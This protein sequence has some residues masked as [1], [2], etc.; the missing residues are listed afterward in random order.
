MAGWN[1]TDLQCIRVLLIGPNAWIMKIDEV[2]TVQVVDKDFFPSRDHVEDTIR[3]LDKHQIT[4]FAYPSKEENRNLVKSIR[5][6]G[7]KPVYDSLCTP[8]RLPL[9]CEGSEYLREYEHTPGEWLQILYDIDHFPQ[10]RRLECHHFLLLK[11]KEREKILTF[12]GSRSKM[13]EF[14]NSTGLTRNTA[15]AW[16]QIREFDWEDSKRIHK[17][18]S[19]DYVERRPIFELSLPL[20]PSFQEWYSQYSERSR[21]EGDYGLCLSMYFEYNYPCVGGFCIIE[22]IDNNY[23]FDL[24]YSEDFKKKYNGLIQDLQINLQQKISVDFIELRRTS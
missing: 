12:H 5:D 17:L 22:E 13:I 8:I 15:I 23:T 14:L 6:N 4:S 1:P 18:N 2:F 20:T 24:D 3:L 19:Y 16:L 21:I 9:V 10:P 11:P 7:L